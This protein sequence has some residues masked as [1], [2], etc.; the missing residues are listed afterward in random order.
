MQLTSKPA[1]HWWALF[2]VCLTAIPAFLDF[3]IVNTALPAI[4]TQFSASVL[5]LQWV[6][7]I[8]G[9]FVAMLMI[10]AGR[11]GDIFGRR[12]LMYLGSVIFIIAAAGG[13]FA[14]SIDMLIAFR[15]LMGIGAAFLFILSG[16]VLAETADR[17]N[18]QKVIGIYA[19]V[20]GIGLA[21]GPFLG[22]FLVSVLSWRWVMWVNL[23]FLIVGLSICMASMGSKPGQTH[24]AKIDWG[25]FILLLVGVASLVNGILNGAQSGWV[26]W[27]S[28]GL[29]VVGL[30]V[31]AVLYRFELKRAA[32]LL[33]MAVFQK[34]ILLMAML[35]CVA[36][37]FFSYVF[38]FFDPLYLI[39]IR[40]YDAFIAGMLLL[41]IPAA[42]VVLSFFS[43]KLIVKLGLK[44]LLLFSFFCALAGSVCHGFFTQTTPVWFVIFSFI[45]MGITWGLANIGFLSAAHGVV[46][47]QKVGGA[48][49]TIATA[50]NI[51]GS[52][53][54]AIGAVVF[55]YFE[56]AWL[57]ASA[58]GVSGAGSAVVKH[59]LKVPSDID[60]LANV[61]HG[62]SLEM[63]IEHVKSAFLNGFH[64][65][66]ILFSV[67][68]FL[69]LALAVILRYKSDS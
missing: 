50:W 29:L 32:P 33:E 66:A 36:A 20:T 23:P 60:K 56:K 9:I 7:N 19:A 67:V 65:L 40:D 14:S 16:A 52:V 45:L 35:N 2:G 63:V 55:Y 48:I 42:Q 31:L 57:T 53:C 8:Y 10:V 43:N 13:G 26:H 68:S 4:Q 1:I 46:E 18:Q 17:D 54:L 11:F 15:A 58:S 47:E 3:T 24:D 22:G 59:V 44:N 34:P 30:I 6:T 69:L 61:F 5:K 21:I 64:S 62:N 25:G 41:A 38:F 27:S 12:R 28:S 51:S 37:G 49:G 39:V